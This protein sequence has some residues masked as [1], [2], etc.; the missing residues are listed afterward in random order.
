MENQTEQTKA[1]NT[2]ST[3]YHLRKPRMD[4]KTQEKPTEQAKAN[5]RTNNK[6][7][8]RLKTGMSMIQSQATA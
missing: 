2:T 8:Q 6:K 7:I 1:L 4:K 3:N 5:Q